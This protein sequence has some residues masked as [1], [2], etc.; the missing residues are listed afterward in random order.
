MT[1]IIKEELKCKEISE[2]FTEFW[3]EIWVRYCFNKAI[4][5]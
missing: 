3:E 1:Q 4:V 2:K 5:N